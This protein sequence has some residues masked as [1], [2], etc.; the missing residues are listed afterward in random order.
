MS[1]E[2]G[3]NVWEV[4][5]AEKL[6]VDHSDPLP[7]DMPH[8]QLEDIS[9]RMPSSRHDLDSG[10]MQGALWVLQIDGGATTK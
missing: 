3:E 7:T 6:V 4:M 1:W 8:V 5:D 2:S 9:L 10:D